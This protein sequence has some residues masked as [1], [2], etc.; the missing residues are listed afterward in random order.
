MN[1]LSYLS[2]KTVIKKSSIQ[3]RGL[4]AIKLIKKG[5]IVALKGG[6]IYDKKVHQKIEK[7]LGPVDIQITENFFIG[8][9]TKKEIKGCMIFSNHSCNPNIGLQGQIVFIALRNIKAGEELTHDW[10][11]TDDE[12][13]RMKCNCGAKN[14]R[15]IITGKDW[16][17][18][19]LHKKYGKYFSWYLLK[20]IKEK[21]DK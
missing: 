16:K 13:Y 10:A 5:E 4:F 15:G 2:P 17:K 18:K 11:M 8:P 7:E 20:K 12:P 14:C 3:G 9:L 1:N 21:A 6:H 19:N